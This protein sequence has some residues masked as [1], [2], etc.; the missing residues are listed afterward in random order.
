METVDSIKQVIE[1][2]SNQQKKLFKQ[3]YE[4]NKA[5][6]GDDFKQL[7]IIRAQMAIAERKMIR[8]YDI[9]D[10]NRPTLNI[11]YSHFMQRQEI[12]N[13]NNQKVADMNP[14]AGI[15]LAGKYGCGKSIM[16]EAYCKL[17]NDL[18]N[19]NEERIE[20]IHSIDL[21]YNIKEK[22]IYPWIRKPLLIHDIG[23]EF[24]M[25]KDFGTQLKPLSDLFAVRAEIGALT[26]GD[27]NFSMDMIG[28]KYQKFIQKRFTEFMNYIVLEG[29]SRR[30][31]FVIK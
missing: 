5:I 14:Y 22:G 7:F 20:V 8:K 6:S 15:L 24:D 25:A 9:D 3:I 11:L 26:F 10:N 23:K 17:L 19:P 30:K 31:E 16:I 2:A 21:A 1:R 29:D 13:E 28:D 27:T 4:R 18:M 12:Y